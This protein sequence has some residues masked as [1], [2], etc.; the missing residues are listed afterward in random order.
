MKIF[1]V[2]LEINPS[3][4]G[5]SFTG[6]DLVDSLHQHLKK[7]CGGRCFGVTRANTII[8]EVHVPCRKE[9][10]QLIGTFL[11]IFQRQGRKVNLVIVAAPTKPLTEAEQQIGAALLTIPTKLTK[12]YF[13]Q[14]AEGTYLVSNVF[15]RQGHPVFTDFVGAA[16][17]RAEQW[18]LIRSLG[19]AQRLCRVFPS[20]AHFQRWF[21]GMRDFL[22]GQSP[23]TRL[24]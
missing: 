11:E 8:F 3:P 16:D 7:S 2:R 12:S 4:P 19:A 17:T 6:Q 18:Q 22:N 5:F 14:I 13:M 21:S 23:P 15:N 9:L 24:S 1:Q 20:D 10:E